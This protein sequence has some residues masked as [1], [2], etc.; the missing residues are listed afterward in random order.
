M[1][2]TLHGF[3]LSSYVRTARMA[4]VE[5]GVD[6][7]LDPLS[8]GDAK[9]QGLHPF[10]KIPVLDHDGF[11]LFETLA[12]CCYVDA[13]F[14]GPG[15]QPSDLKRRALDLLWIS[16]IDGVVY[17]A[18]IRRFVLQYA[19]PKDGVPDRRVIDPALGK[20]RHQLGVL[21]AGYGAHD[22][23][24]GDSL[25]SA[26]LYLAP[27]PFYVGQIPEG[28]A[29]LSAVPGVRRGTAAMEARKSF[30]DAFANNLVREVLKRFL[31]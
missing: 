11:P 27:I 31:Q 30:G 10:G 13:S 9:A 14:D 8:P 3:P 15:L 18:M 5:K 26:D 7:R 25:G 17:D 21:D 1:T 22:Y 20:A 24:T 23:L 16:A 29:L 4:C 2:L 19:F 6:Y 12:I 28:E